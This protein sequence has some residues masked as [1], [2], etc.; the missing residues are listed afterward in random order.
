VVGAG[1]GLAAAIGTLRFL[2]GWSLK[3]LIYVV[4]QPA[5]WDTVFAAFDPELQKILGLPLGIVALAS[6]F[7]V[8]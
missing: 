2:Y 7:P 8:I 4:L 6:L 1:A 3:P 5:L